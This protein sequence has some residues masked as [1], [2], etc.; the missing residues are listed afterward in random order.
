MSKKQPAYNR[1]SA[2]MQFDFAITIGIIVA[3]STRQ[4]LNKL[5]LCKN[6]QDDFDYSVNK[7]YVPPV[8]LEISNLKIL[9]AVV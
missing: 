6:L 4:D 2:K 5:S 1:M 3:Q 7:G 9:N 8:P